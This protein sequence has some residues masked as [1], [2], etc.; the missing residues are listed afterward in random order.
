MT[1]RVVNTTLRNYRIWVCLPDQDETN[2]LEVTDACASEGGFFSVSDEPLGLGEGRIRTTGELNLIVPVGQESLYSSWENPSQWAVGNHVLIKIADEAGT[3]RTHPR[4]HLYILTRPLPPYP[5]NYKIKVELADLMTLNEQKAGPDD[6]PITTGVSRA[7]AIGRVASS[8]GIS[9][10]FSIAGSNPPKLNDSG[11]SPIEQLSEMAAASGCYLW[12]TASGGMGKRGIALHP[13]YRL[14]KH[15]VGIDDAAQFEPVQNDD[16][17]SK[18]KVVSPGDQKNDKN[19]DGNNDGGDGNQDKE[20]GDIYTIDYGPAS[21]VL[22]GYAGD[23]IV[24]IRKESW[25]WQGHVFTR[26]IEEMKPRAMVIPE[27]V[28]DAM[29]DASPKSYRFVRPDAFM[30]IPSLVSDEVRTYEQSSQGRLE[31]TIVQEYRCIGELFADFYQRYPIN[32]AKQVPPDFGARII[33]QR[34]TTTYTYQRSEHDSDSGK[35]KTAN[36]DTGGQVRRIFTQSYQPVGTVAGAATDWAIERRGS[37]TPV[38]PPRI[39]LETLTLAA[40]SD[41]FWIRR[42]RKEWEQHVVEKQAG[43]VRSGPISSF[44]ALYTIKN[45]ITVS[46]DG[47]AQPPTADRRRSDPTQDKPKQ[48]IESEAKTKSG[49]EYNGDR[50]ITNDYITTQQEADQ[51]ASLLAG[52]SDARQRGFRITTT[53]R[54]GWFRYAPMSRIDLAWNGRTYIGVT[55]LVNWTLAGDQAIVLA[56]GM[57][58]GHTPD[59]STADNYQFPELPTLQPS[60]PDPEP[61]DDSGALIP[62]DSS[63]QEIVTYQ[64]FVRSRVIRVRS[65]VSFTACAYPLGN[66]GTTAVAMRSTNRVAFR[67]LVSMRSISRV[68]LAPVP[69]ITIRSVAKAKLQAPPGVSARLVSMVH[70][71]EQDPSSMPVVAYWTLDGSPWLDS[72]GNLHT[73]TQTGTVLT[74]TGAVGNAARFNSSL[75][76]LYSAD[77]ELAM[78]DRHWKFQCKLFWA[79][80][81]LG[82]NFCAGKSG[83]WELRIDSVSGGMQI[84]ARLYNGYSVAG[85]LTDVEATAVYPRD[86]WLDITVE[87]LPDTQ[88]FHLKINDDLYTASYAGVTYRDPNQGQQVGGTFYLGR[89]RNL[90][91]DEVKLYKE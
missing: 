48:E 10:S 31:T 65:Q 25:R 69:A 91:L 77:T 2:G 24:L 57:I 78:N 41:Q 34:T 40:Q 27:A 7:D 29:Q 53:L 81:Q 47:N 70:F 19:G 13:D 73:L 62:G 16:R 36:K 14:F 58:T 51:L 43:Q 60:D 50:T 11:K 84:Y 15:I 20:S 86:T 26:H 39:P 18:V 85:D 3:L 8:I 72:S 28:Y 80:G 66:Q 54:D 45:E 56:E 4:S 38:A 87:M 5:G 63:T 89:L 12:H 22:E 68:T 46:G 71:R 37:I 76:S 32:L 44:L 21:S 42:T 75:A 79:S 35:T 17:P 6:P 67:E 83:D 49:D 64:Q 90:I 52:L 33:A 82:G 55:N 61:I 23:V 9:T 74:V 88:E 59:T 30:L 1:S